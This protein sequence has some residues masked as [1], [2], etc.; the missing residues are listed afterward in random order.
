MDSPI[1]GPGSSDDGV[2]VLASR[3]E[4]MDPASRDLGNTF[5]FGGAFFGLQASL[6]ILS[7]LDMF[8]PEWM[9]ERASWLS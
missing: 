4:F 5:G 9:P 6:T 1:L 8:A 7:K 3:S 2:Y